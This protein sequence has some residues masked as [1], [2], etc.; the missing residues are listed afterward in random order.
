MHR[1]SQDV[2]TLADRRRQ[3]AH[4]L[5]FVVLLGGGAPGCAAL[6]N[7]NVDAVPV[8]LVPPE[9]L[10]PSHDADQ[11]IPLTLLGQPEPPEYQLAPGDVLGVHVDGVL[12]DHNQPLAAHVPPLV[13]IRDQRHLPPALGY[14]LP[15]QADGTVALPLDGNVKVQGLTLRQAA[16]AIRKVYVDEQKI[17]AETD[18]VIVT[19]L[20]SR[21]EHII[22]FRQEAAN[23]LIGPEGVT[24]GTKRGTGQEVDLPAYENDVL[25]ALA[26]T[27]GLPG[28]DAYNEIVIYRNCFRTQA[29]RQEFLQG[30][31][32]KA[33]EHAPL[34]LVPGAQAIHIPLR[35][36]PGVPLPV[37]PEDVILQTGDVVY[38]EGRDR[39][40]FYTAGLLPPG[41][42]VLPRDH[43]LD[44]IEAISQV[45]GPLVNG[46]FAVSN[47]SGA[48]IAPGIGNPSPS[49]LVV[50]R[51]APHG[52]RVPI[53]V[54]LS[55]ALRDPRESIRVQ[56]GDVLILQEKPQEALARYFYQ[57][58]MNFNLI[59]T[60]I[61]S[62]FATGV[63]DVSAPDRLPSRLGTVT[64]PQQ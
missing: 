22:V 37:R 30:L 52:G 33:L 46:A 26:L 5:L 28:L 40:L 42:H 24:S 14:P 35:L 50:L 48:V 4:V 64:I 11:T 43:D 45:H 23:L 17:K 41:A 3:S 10:A 8:R 29:G 32:A 63:L 12:G 53:Q 62:R 47:L 54:D 21:Q 20:T 36:P 18:R 9:L 49:L 7:P 59:W 2:P 25:H 16:A 56:A 27:G 44:V 61:H 19:L 34:A 39:E 51:K 38:I 31:E 13:Q 15:V 55:R 1:S 58:L 57:T 60:P 6:T